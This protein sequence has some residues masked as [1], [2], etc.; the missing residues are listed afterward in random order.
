M[1][2]DYDRFIININEA[3]GEITR[4]PFTFRYDRFEVLKDDSLVFKVGVSSRIRG[5][6]ENGNLKVNIIGNEINDHLEKSMCFDVISYDVDNIRWAIEKS[7]ENKNSDSIS[8]D[9]MALFYLK[10]V[11]S[12]ISFVIHKTGIQVSFFSDKSLGLLK[13]S[14]ELCID[15]RKAI[16]LFGNGK[17]EE[18]RS[19][20]LEIYRSVKSDPEQLRSAEDYES[21]G[22]CFLIMLDM[23]FSNDIDVLQFIISVG[24]LC[25]SLAIEDDS[26]NL[27]LYKDRLLLL[28][29]G[30][31]P[32]RYTVM[33]ALRLISSMFSLSSNFADIE[34][35]DA[36]YKMEV[37]DLENNP[38]LCDKIDFLNNRKNELKE[39]IDD[40]F[41]MS[42]RTLRDVLISGTKNHQDLLIYIENKVIVNGD[43]DF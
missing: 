10:G 8:P 11:L 7:I 29:F 31:I 24:Y 43:I 18:S 34:A 17:K 30:N 15:A 5:V 28:N 1:S 13:P 20:L 40:D 25:T 14:S 36:I 38:E 33:S 22:R 42:D 23:N 9:Y 19:V 6:V 39:M 41:F 3:G 16:L 35:R 32:F 12:K 21:L 4:K 26:E 27:N 37:V 2:E